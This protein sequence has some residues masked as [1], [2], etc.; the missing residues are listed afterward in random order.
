M[1]RDAA[2]L[3]ALNGIWRHFPSGGEQVAVLKDISLTVREGEMVAIIGA[4]GSGKSTLMNIIGCLDTP[5]RGEMRIHGVATHAADSG[6]LAKLRSQYIGSIRRCLPPSAGPAR[7][8]CCSASAW[9]SV[10]T[11]GPPSFPAVNSSGSA[12][13][14]R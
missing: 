2:P 13:R 11:T 14:E 1:K 9:A 7:R 5:T 12:F 10:S 8:I 3:I 4:S 6:Q